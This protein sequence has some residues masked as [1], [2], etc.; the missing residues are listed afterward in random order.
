MNIAD[1]AQLGGVEL[2]H[3]IAT[4][5]VS[6]VEVEA[7]ARDALESAD[8]DLNAL[9]IAPFA[10]A[11]DYAGDGVLGGGAL[12]HQ[13]QRPGRAGRAVLSG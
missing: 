1:Y 13:G 4:D 12:C 2:A 3:L 5:Q 8:A 10:S 7:V 9:A 6:K 11:L